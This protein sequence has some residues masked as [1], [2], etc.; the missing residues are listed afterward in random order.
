MLADLAGRRLLDGQ[1]AEEGFPKPPIPAQPLLDHSQIFNLI[2]VGK[3][4]WFLPAWVAARFPRPGITY[5]SVE[6]LEPVTLSVAWLDGTRSAAVAAFVQAAQTVAQ[7]ASSVV[8]ESLF[9]LT[10]PLAPTTNVQNRSLLT[11]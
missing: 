5:R 7:D 10:A 11:R 9:A 3:A 4:V 6:G 1:A 2:E 8:E